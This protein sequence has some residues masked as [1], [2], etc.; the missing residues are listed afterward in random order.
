MTYRLIRALFRAGLFGFFR[1]IDVEGED[2]VP[3]TGP[4]LLVANHVNAFV[5]ALLILT[6]LDRRVTLT[7]K[8]TL[9]SDPMLRPVLAGLDVVLLHRSQDVPQDGAPDGATSAR[10]RNLDAL[11]GCRRRL[12]EDGALCVFPEGVSHSDP[13]IRPLRT[14]AARIALDFLARTGRP[15]PIV[16]VALHYEAKGRFRSAAGVVFGEPMEAAA[17]LGVNAGAGPRELTA[18][19]DARI[20]RLT[21]NFDS[22]EERELFLRAA[23]LVQVSGVEPAPV[24]REQPRGLVSGVDVI[25]RLQAG[26]E[27]LDHAGRAERE[28]LAHRVSALYRKLGRLGITAEELALPVDLARAAFFVV[29][30]LEILLVGFPLALWGAL[31]H[32]PAYRLLRVLVRRLSKDDDHV[33]TNAVFLGV[34]LFGVAYV[35]QTALVAW[36]T[37]PVWALAYLLSLP[38]AGAVALLYRDRA[39][40]VFRRTRT[41]LLFLRRPAFRR[42]LADEA[43]SITREVR[44]LAMEYDDV[45]V[46]DPRV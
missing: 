45:D 8:S 39:G 13:S 35:V 29:R 22:A 26:A 1:R 44:R 3:R 31:N 5:D 23:E 2:R 42:S 9:R 38:L 37:S 36:L 30:E 25:H 7:A 41:F 18:E 6:R 4:V 27:W 17:W 34:P 32:Q 28:D 14:G 33:A 16:P 15:L 43:D 10:G 40:G 19:L 21:T 24:G 46:T 12:E 20:R 11:A